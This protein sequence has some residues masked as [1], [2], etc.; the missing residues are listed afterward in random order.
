[1]KTKTTTVKITQKLEDEMLITFVNW[2]LIEINCKLNHIM[3]K[4]VHLVTN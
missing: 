2:Q 3:A 1:L 4:A